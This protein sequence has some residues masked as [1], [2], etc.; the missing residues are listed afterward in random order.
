MQLVSHAM[1]N[2]SAS[3]ETNTPTEDCTLHPCP[4]NFSHPL[5]F[6][7]ALPSHDPS[8]I[9]R[10][11]PILMLVTSCWGVGTFI[12]LYSWVSAHMQKINLCLRIV[13]ICGD[14]GFHFRSW[15]ALRW[16]FSLG[17][18][19][20]CNTDFLVVKYFVKTITSIE[21][22]IRRGLFQVLKSPTASN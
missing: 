22:C 4:R 11:C 9:A 15:L 17:K 8:C 1:G 6:T 16:A 20:V 12:N 2:D 10:T 18:E 21:T 19:G 3:E 13:T 7:L 14:V 5:T